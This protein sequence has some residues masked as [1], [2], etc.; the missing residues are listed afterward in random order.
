[1]N[2]YLRVFPVKALQSARPSSTCIVAQ[3]A[4]CTLCHICN[5]KNIKKPP[6]VSADLL[7][8]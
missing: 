6:G 3:S 5:R 2:A 7:T 1:M 4:A 8:S